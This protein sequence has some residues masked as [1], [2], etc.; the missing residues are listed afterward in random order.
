MSSIGM[1]GKKIGMTQIFNDKGSAIPVT[2]LEIGPCTI[3]N[4][5]HSEYNKIYHIQIGYE[6]TN[7]KKLTKALLGKFSKLQL[8]CFKYLKEYKNDDNSNNLQIGQVLTVKELQVGNY[9]N[10]SAKSIGKGFC[11]YQKRHHFSRGPMSH[12]SKNH[13]QPGSIGAGTTPGRVFPG[14][15]MS[16]RMGHN[17]VTIKNLKILDVDTKNNIVIIKGSVPGKNGNILYLYKK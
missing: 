15:R 3:T 10:I 13:R 2:I 16:G 12:G 9:I 6:Y 17:K 5:K 14:K 4:I 7:P 1:F 8:P 11:G